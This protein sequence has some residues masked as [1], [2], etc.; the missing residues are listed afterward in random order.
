MKKDHIVLHVLS[1]REGGPGQRWAM[2]I[3]REA[4]IPCTHASSPFV[5]HY[6]VK[7]LTVNKRLVKRAQR[8]IYG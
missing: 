4:G 6:A 1:Q 2:S 8:L 3:L 7:L 5:G